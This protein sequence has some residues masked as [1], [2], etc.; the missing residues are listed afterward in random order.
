[1]R[2]LCVICC[3]ISCPVFAPVLPSDDDY[4]LLF[5]GFAIASITFVFWIVTVNL[6]CCLR[7]EWTKAESAHSVA[8]TDF[9]SWWTISVIV[10]HTP[11][12]RLLP[13]A[14]NVAVVPGMP[15]IERKI[16]CDFESFTL[17]E[18]S[19]VYPQAQCQKEPMSLMVGTCKVVVGSLDR[20]SEPVSPPLLYQSQ[21]WHQ[22]SYW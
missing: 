10:S 6:L 5:A 21:P 16:L 8:S 17:Y 19:L 13:V 15:P 20:H 1:L 2:E 14:F 11:F 18:T 12:V 4:G 3:N 9:I 22:W 7:R